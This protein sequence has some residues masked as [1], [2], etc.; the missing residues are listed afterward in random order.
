MIKGGRWPPSESNLASKKDDNPTCQPPVNIAVGPGG[1]FEDIND[2]LDFLSKKDNRGLN[3]PTN[4]YQLI[5]KNG[6]HR[7]KTDHHTNINILRLRSQ[8]WHPTMG[9]SYIQGAGRAQEFI[10][11]FYDQYQKNVGGLGP[12]KLDVCGKRVT[13]CGSINPDFS[14]LV[15]GDNL[16][17][18]NKKDKIICYTVDSAKCNTIWIKQCFDNDCVTTGEGFWIGNRSTIQVVGSRKLIVQ[19]RLEYLGLTIEPAGRGMN[20]NTD[21]DENNLVRDGDRLITGADAGHNQFHHGFTSNRMSFIGNY[22]WTSPSVHINLIHCYPS[23]SGN[24]LYQSYIGA[25]SKAHIEGANVTHYGSTYLRNM[26]ALYAFNNGSIGSIAS[27]FLKCNIGSRAYSGNVNYYGSM[28]NGCQLG[29]EA[30]T[31]QLAARNLALTG[32]EGPLFMNCST[33]LKLL[34]QSRSDNQV[35]STMNNDVDLDLDGQ[36]FSSLSDYTSGSPGAIL[37][38]LYYE[39]HVSM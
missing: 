8:S 34:G 11:Q 35:I 7:L 36:L 14:D 3:S 20:L 32:L 16:F 9:M 33:A 21:P 29:A 22:D 1:D 13:V 27:C 18:F 26:I 31:G 12:W 38:I 15:C 10:P 19:N 37:S 28:F 24:M 30:R 23:Y 5:L 4:G 39:E 2:A 6:V 17:W 25:N